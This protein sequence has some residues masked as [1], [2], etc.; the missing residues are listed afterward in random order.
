MPPPK[1]DQE[2]LGRVIAH[3]FAKLLKVPALQGRWYTANC[4]A[5]MLRQRHDFS[6]AC[7]FDV[8]F[9]DQAIKERFW[10]IGSDGGAYNQS[11]AFRFTKPIYWPGNRE[12]VQVLFY[13]FTKPG[14]FGVDWSETPEDSLVKAREPDSSYKGWYEFFEKFDKMPA[15]FSLVQRSTPPDE[16]DEQI[17]VLRE[18]AVERQQQLEERLNQTNEEMAKEHEA[19]TKEAK[20]KRA[21]KKRENWDAHEG[22]KLFRPRKNEKPLD[23]L[24]RRMEI[25]D[26]VINEYDGFRLVLSE[27]DLTEH[28]IMISSEHIEERIFISKQ[29]FSVRHR[30]TCLRL[31]YSFVLE[32]MGEGSSVSFF[33]CGEE[34]LRRMGLNS[35]GS[36]KNRVTEYNVQFR[37]REKFPLT[38]SLPKG[39]KDRLSVPMRVQRRRRNNTNEN[40]SVPAPDDDDDDEEEE[41]TA[42]AKFMVKNRYV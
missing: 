7:E 31:A 22:R 8:S 34:A 17:D 16:V 2:Q 36:N 1:R 6:D 35:T 32:R 40:L 4:L 37:D 15:F 33:S 39:R 14:R 10:M 18:I 5:N 30:A 26:K 42:I 20:A 12:A 28:D 23:A 29:I 27:E 9:M 24:R 11:G 25:L 19:R 21:A 38:L 13:H 41:N 3:A